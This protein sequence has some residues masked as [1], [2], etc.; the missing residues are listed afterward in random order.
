MKKLQAGF[1]LVELMITLAVAIIVL[2]VGIPM[3]GSIVAN[4]RAIAQANLFITA[5]NMAKSEA[6]TQ[7][8]PVTVCANDDA[9]NVNAAT[10]KCG[11]SNDWAN[12]W[13]VFQDNGANTGV[14]D[15]G[16]AIMQLWQAPAVAG[17]NLV[18]TVGFIN[19][20][21]R[22]ENSGGAT[23]FRLSQDDSKGSQTRCVYVNAGGQI[24]VAK[25]ASAGTC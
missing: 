8:I 13:F 17:T 22:G 23:N 1:T 20:T 6:V 25:I 24:R 16:E 18:S 11:N 2:A 9:A 4:N 21:S 15:T 19:Y 7:G 12:G 3:Y 10:L 14:R 5:L